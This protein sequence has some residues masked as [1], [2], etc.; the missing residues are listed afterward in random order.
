MSVCVCNFDHQ[1]I[2]ASQ[3][4]QFNTRANGKRKQRK[5]RK[6]EIPIYSLRTG[7]ERGGSTRKIQTNENPEMKPFIIIFACITHTH[8]IYIIG[9]IYFGIIFISIPS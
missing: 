5:K 7:G 4:M 3:S 1:N 6:Q 8:T 9:L 2:K